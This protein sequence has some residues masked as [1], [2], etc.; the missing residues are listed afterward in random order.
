MKEKG[1]TVLYGTVSPEAKANLKARG[2]Q[3]NEEDEEETGE[4]SV[5]IH[6]P[7]FYVLTAID[8]APLSLFFPDSGNTVKSQ[9]EREQLY[10]RP[11]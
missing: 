3:I 4:V 9:E 8:I 5:V 1:H 10:G 6:A 7:L 2:F 11:E